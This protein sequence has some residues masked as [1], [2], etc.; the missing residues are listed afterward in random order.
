V[1]LYVVLDGFLLLTNC[2]LDYQFC[3][4]GVQ[5]CVCMCAGKTNVDVVYN[6]VK[7]QVLRVPWMHCI[8]GCAVSN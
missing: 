7:Y 5:L 1:T 8:E 6:A 2:F 3:A 4:H